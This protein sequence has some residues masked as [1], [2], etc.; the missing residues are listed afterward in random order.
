MH[1]KV[2]RSRRVFVGALV[3]GQMVSRWG[4]P[5]YPWAREMQ[6]ALGALV[7][8]SLFWPSKD[9]DTAGPYSSDHKR[10]F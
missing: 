10:V 1:A 2:S 7:L 9:A 4:F 5:D 3:V 6:T 8:V